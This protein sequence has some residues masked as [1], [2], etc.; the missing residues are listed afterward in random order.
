FNNAPQ[1]NTSFAYDPFGNLTQTT[2]PANNQINVSYDVMG[3]KIQLNDPDLGIINYSVDPVGRTWQQV[4][5]N[6]KAKGQATTFKFDMLDRTI[7]RLEP[8]LNSY[9]IYD[10]LGATGATLT[11]AQITSCQASHSCGKQVESYTAP[12]ANGNVGMIN[13][14]NSSKESDT[15]TN[16]DSLGRPANSTVTLDA[17]LNMTFYSETDYD[18]WGRPITQIS[19]HGTDP[20]KVFDQR[21]NA[22]GYLQS[23]ERSGL[24]LWKAVSQDASN[25]VITAHIATAGGANDGL[26]VTRCYDTN[27]GRLDETVAAPVSASVACG[28]TPAVATVMESYYYDVLGNVNQRNEAW[29]QGIT[30]TVASQS[31]SEGF[32][33]DGLNRILT[34]TVANQAQQVFSYSADGNIL[35]NPTAGTYIYYTGGT[36]GA[37]P[38]AV[39]SV[40]GAPGTF[41]YDADGN[42]LTGNSRTN[43]WTSFDMPLNMAYSG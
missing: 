36:S 3:H 38:H 19:Q 7:S 43:T 34:S 41:T 12:L 10:V 16:F 32:T 40:S 13:S 22:F 11:A 4:S 26:I 27:T 21:Y 9:F 6:E 30:G 24:T 35:V 33:Y 28:T 8:D 20:Q 42:Q 37:G 15:V 31:F 25:R 39:K 29:N 1:T 23:V 5:P 18:V 2:D 14:T 17:S